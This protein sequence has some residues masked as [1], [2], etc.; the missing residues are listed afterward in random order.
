MDPFGNQ[1]EDALAEAVRRLG[2][3]GFEAALMQLFH[4]LAAPDNLLVLA[5]RDA[6]PPQVLYV[7]SGDSPVFDALPT[8]Y[9]AGAYLL[10]PFHDLHLS[11]APAGMYRLLDVAP[12][13]FQRSRYYLE[14]YQETT[15][16]DELTYVAYPAPGVSLNL[17]LGRDRTSGQTFAPREVEAVARLAPV[18]LAL[19]ER[20]WAGLTATDAAPEDVAG[21][22]V[23]ALAPR[24]ISLSPRQAEV[25]LL[26]LRGHSS[27]SIALRLGVSVQTVK[28]FR[29]QLYGKCGISSQA[30]LFALLLPLLKPGAQGRA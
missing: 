17:C 25:A 13:A 2:R 28:V 10:D 1:A 22:L 29:R 7:Q 23:A 27:T 12:D 15:L 18:V 6:G 14:Y 20:H 3:P 24:G 26:I 4:R 21:G 8:T 30:E 11:R 5:Y 19:A 16:I 9:L